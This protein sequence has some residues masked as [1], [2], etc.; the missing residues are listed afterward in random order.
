MQEVPKEGG[1]EE[2]KGVEEEGP[3]PIQVEI[4]WKKFFPAR[5]HAI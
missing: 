4:S 3:P 5:L 2:V 1:G